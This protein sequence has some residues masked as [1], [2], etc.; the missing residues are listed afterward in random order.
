[1]GSIQVEAPM[2][3]EQCPVTRTLTLVGSRW[4]PLVIYHL[5]AGTHRYG[6]LQRALPGISPKTLADRLHVLERHGLLTR[7]VYPDKPPRVEYTLTPSGHRL[8]DILDSVADW[9]AEPDVTI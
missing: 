5:H 3:P 7:T 4:T 2:T 8:G 6:E 9:A 1:M